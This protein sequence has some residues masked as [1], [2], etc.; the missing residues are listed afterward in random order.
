[1]NISDQA[2]HP[3]ISVRDTREG[4]RQATIIT[5]SGGPFPT[6]TEH[7]RLLLAPQHWDSK[8]AGLGSSPVWSDTF[9]SEA[10]EPIARSGDIIMLGTTSVTRGMLYHLAASTA[11][12]AAGADVSLS[13]ANLLAIALDTGVANVGG[14]LLKG[15]VSIPDALIN[16][17]PVTGAPVYV[18]TTTAGEY[19]FTATST[20][21]DRVRVVGYCLAVS[22][23]SHVFLYF[24]PDKTGIT[25]S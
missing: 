21:A 3:I 19:D 7:D 5:G 23:D 16:G 17:T 13:E 2:G 18:S 22:T 4:F 12:V 9:T 14:M 15:V 10:S 24:D 1:M 8:S 20:S 25:L 11:W 6:F